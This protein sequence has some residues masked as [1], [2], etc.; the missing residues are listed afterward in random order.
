MLLLA[1]LAACTKETE[2]MSE[3]PSTEIPTSEVPEPTPVTS[4]KPKQR[5]VEF[6][7]MTADIEKETFL[8]REEITIE[9]Y[10]TNITSE[11]YE[12]SPFPPL[13][14]IKAPM[15]LVS[16]EL[17][18]S[19]PAGATAVT[20]Q[21]N[22][23]RKYTPIWDQQDEQKKQVP[24]GYYIFSIPRGGTL[25]DMAVVGSV[26]I[27]PPEGVIEQ[28]IIVNES[29]TVKD[30]TITMN[31]VE[32]TNK[33]IVFYAFNADYRMSDV[34]QSEHLPYAEYFLD[35]DAVREGTQTSTIG[36][37]SNLNGLEYVWTMSIPVP[38]GTESL[39]FII[40]EF[41]ELK[42]PWEFKVSLN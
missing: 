6:I 1:M 12:I 2:P 35:S 7:R 26:Y 38:K 32:L 25:K 29:Q 23:T 24:Y 20:L 21:P 28:V 13:I 3:Q 36:G 11:P 18:R 10:F 37:G 31:R 14:D 9:I 33:G 17:I 19:L 40:S 4:P 39:T 8:P 34:P 41:W 27:L 22:E 16:G 42:G 15:R 5:P 30:V